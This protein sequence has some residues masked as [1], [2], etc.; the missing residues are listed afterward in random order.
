MADEM[1]SNPRTKLSLSN[2]V[3]FLV[4]PTGARRFTQGVCEDLNLG[5]AQSKITV[6]LGTAVDILKYATTAAMTY[7]LI[8]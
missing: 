5:Y 6:G 1:R 4:S 8:R 7:E 3:N 2:M